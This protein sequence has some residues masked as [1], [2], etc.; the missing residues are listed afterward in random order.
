MSINPLDDD[1]GGFLVSINDENQHSLWL[2]FAD[3]PAGWR[4]VRGE[5]DRVARQ[6]YIGKNCPNMR[7]KSLRQTL[8]A[9]RAIDH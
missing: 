7:P 5:A 8:A 1:N 2:V 9:G 6:H 4:A 3:V